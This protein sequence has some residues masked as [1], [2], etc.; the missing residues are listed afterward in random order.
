MG[1][2]LSKIPSLADKIILY[3][4]WILVFLIPLTFFPDMNPE[5]L[6]LG[7]VY[8]IASIVLFSWLLK[9]FI[10]KKLIIRQNIFL[11]VVFLFVLV[12]LLTIPFSNDL[13]TSFFGQYKRFHGGFL[14]YFAYSSIFFVVVNNF[15]IKKAKQTLVIAVVS[16]FFVSIFGIVHYF[17]LDAPRAYATLQIPGSYASYIAIFFFISIGFMLESKDN[18]VKSLF[19]ITTAILYLGFTL[20]RLYLFLHERHNFRF[21]SWNYYAYSYH[22][23]F[24][25]P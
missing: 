5:S 16:A 25:S 9:A 8:L 2:I 11:P 3:S 4:I 10:I 15:N 23:L 6:K 13:N 21:N 1:K 24:N 17:A 14:S 19:L 20:F 22:Y 12:L 18:L 7:I